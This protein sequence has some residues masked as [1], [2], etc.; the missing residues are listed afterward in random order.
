MDLSVRTA[1]TFTNFSHVFTFIRPVE[2]DGRL[3][4]VEATVSGGD[5]TLATIDVGIRDGG[6]TTVAQGTGSGMVVPA[7]RRQRRARPDTRRVLA[8]MVFTDVVESTRIADELGDARWA[9]VLAGYHALVRQHVGRAD[10]IEVRSA[11]DGFL[12]RF[13]SPSA[14]V[15]RV[16]DIRDGAAALGLATRSGVHAG[17]CEVRGNELAGLALHVAA[18]LESVAAPGEVLVS[19]TVRHLVAGSDLGFED[20]GVH[21]LR[22]VPGS[23]RL[24]RVVR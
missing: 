17:E 8:T 4:E 18:R 23:W 13:D 9:Q 19:E 2:P 7:A 3:I 5:R 24:C 21:E 12:L 20:A 15:R 10:G 16:C 22:G 6:G 14:A 1:D 11:G